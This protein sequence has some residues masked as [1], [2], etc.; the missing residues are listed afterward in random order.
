MD[1]KQLIEN[2]E[3]L[4]NK[5]ETRTK[6]I[7]EIPR[8]KE[9]GFEDCRVTLQKPTTAMIIS[10]QEHSDNYYQL[11]ECM[12]NPDLNNKEF[13]KAFKV[14]NKSALLKKIFTEEELQDMLI[15]LG[16]ITMTQS[17]AKLVADLK[18]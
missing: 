18:N 2:A 17:R 5:K 11:A 6:I 14:N 13:Q 7:I 1:I 3:E 12:V 10:A 4:K 16:R 9:L 8:F 15:H